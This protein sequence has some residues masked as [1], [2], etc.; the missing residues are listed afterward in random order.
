MNT[1]WHAKS[2]DGFASTREAFKLPAIDREAFPIEME[3]QLLA[4]LT[5][6]ASES[7][8]KQS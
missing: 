2:Q 6:Q 4:S 7:V 3:L 1:P 8:V 5:S